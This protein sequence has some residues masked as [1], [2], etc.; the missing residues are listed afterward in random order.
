MMTNSTVHFPLA[1]TQTTFSI[2]P[3]TALILGIYLLQQPNTFH[4]NQCLYLKAISV[5]ELMFIIPLDVLPYLR[6]YNQTKDLY[7][8]IAL[9]AING[10]A[11]PWLTMTI[12]LTIDRLA[13][14]YLN[15]KYD[16]YI[17]KKLTKR[18]IFM[19][20]TIGAICLFGTCLV[21]YV[22]QY[23]SLK[24]TH[25]VI[26]Q[27]YNV[28]IVISLVF[29]YTYIYKKIKKVRCIN[30]A[31]GTITSSMTT[32]RQTERRS[33]FIPGLIVMSYILF[34][35][36]PQITNFIVLQI[37]KTKQSTITMFL[38]TT[39]LFDFGSLINVLIYIL[40]NKSL[41]RRFL[42]TIRWKT[43]RRF[44]PLSTR[45]IYSASDKRHHSVITLSTIATPYI[46]Y[47]HTRKI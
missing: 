22:Y 38:I 36:V 25:M 39:I 27:I 6:I 17:N 35:M 12:A 26:M 14:V 16:L 29:T 45:A 31:S 47:V 5:A 33:H 3:I 7:D 34:V 40:M 43:L 24:F 23:D 32:K 2:L 8:Y 42:A 18:I 15:I 11:V 46:P 10:C 1:V 41:R 44:I 4:E 30:G 13:Q 21:K 9:Y 37:L 28:G 20:W 19:S